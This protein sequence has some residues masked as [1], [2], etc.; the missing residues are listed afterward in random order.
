MAVIA[1]VSAISFFIH[2]II[3]KKRRKRMMLSSVNNLDSTKISFDKDEQYLNNIMALKN[4]LGFED[5]F[6]FISE[7]TIRSIL[8][9]FLHLI[10]E[11]FRKELTEF[12]R[13]RRGLLNNKSAYSKQYVKERQRLDLLLEQGLSQTLE[14]LSLSEDKY[15][16]SLERAFTKSPDFEKEYT[17]CIV[18]LHIQ[19][20]IEERIKEEDLLGILEYKMIK[21]KEIELSGF[22]TE[23]E[24]RV[25]VK[26]TYIDDL[27]FKCF[28]YENK[29][30]IRNIDQSNSK[31]VKDLLEKYNQ[32]VKASD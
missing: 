17:N 27:A 12:D 18:S 21:W 30:L 29:L 1:G 28:G 9:A 32:L 6:P 10:K 13:V 11:R 2:K 31:E 19:G 22:N 8:R 16:K 14:D 20:D 23:N 24:L 3:K 7:K 4:I 5:K 26:Q 25:S 15:S